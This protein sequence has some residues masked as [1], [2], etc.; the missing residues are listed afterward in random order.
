MIS[1]FKGILPHGAILIC[2]MYI[3]FYLIDRVNTAM[4]FIDNGITKAL[5]VI[6]CVLSAGISV[7]L[8]RARKKAEEA[9]ARRKREAR[10]MKHRKAESTSRTEEHR[11]HSK[12]AA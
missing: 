10:R 9:R 8:I 5:L 4:C 2:N 7:S 1:C 3:V 6:M 12:K 11:K